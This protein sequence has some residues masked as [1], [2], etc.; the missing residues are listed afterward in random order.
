MI[1]NF[2]KIRTYKFLYCIFFAMLNYEQALAVDI[3]DQMSPEWEIQQIEKNLS[4]L[5][6]K[7]N[8]LI[9]IQS[10]DRRFVTKIQA[11]KQLK[12]A[13]DHFE[14]K[15]FRGSAELFHQFIEEAQ[16]PTKEEFMDVWKHLF[17]INLQLKNNS[18]AI[19]YLRKYINS[20]QTSDS[21]N[22]EELKRI[23]N[24][25]LKA[26]NQSRLRIKSPKNL[27]SA[28]QTLKYP[29]S[30]AHEFR[31]LIAYLAQKEGF[32]SIASQWLANTQSFSSDQSLISK[33]LFY[34]G[35]ISTRLG[36]LDLAMNQFRQALIASESEEHEIKSF[37]ELALGRILFFKNRFAEALE[38]YLRIDTESNQYSKALKELS[39]ISAAL[40]RWKD[41]HSYGIRFLAENNMR[42]NEIASF[43]DFI[44]FLNLQAG[45]L[46]QVDPVLDKN[47]EELSKLKKDVLSFGSGSGIEESD[48]ENQV[49]NLAK[50]IR[51]KISEPP[52]MTKMIQVDRSVRILTDKYF[53]LK[54]LISNFILSFGRSKIEQLNSEIYGNYQQ[55]TDMAGQLLR[56]AQH[57]SLVESLALKEQ[58]PLQSRTGIKIIQQGRKKMLDLKD[59]FA[60]GFHF[61]GYEAEIWVVSGQIKNVMN[62]I[63]TLRA[64]LASAE[65]H[66]SNSKS[67]D[68]VHDSKIREKISMIN[69][70]QQRLH[71]PLSELMTVLEDLKYQ[72]IEIQKQA[73]LSHP[74]K[75][76]LDQFSASLAEEEAIYASFT[77]RY[78]NYNQ[79]LLMTD[80]LSAWN[81]WKKLMNLVYIQIDDTEKLM[82][83]KTNQYVSM[84]KMFNKSAEQIRQ[85]LDQLALMKNQIEK[86]SMGYVRGHLVW[87]IDQKLS[88]FHKWQ[89]DSKWISYNKLNSQFQTDLSAYEA[90]KTSLDLYIDQMKQGILESW[91]D[92]LTS[93]F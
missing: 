61:H 4:M 66:I 49:V 9:R 54:A 87:Q 65:F 2:I 68:S 43:S 83:Q 89:A 20:F 30:D 86:G 63:L 23:L 45:Q 29:E 42:H 38:H 44:P 22:F 15:N 85:Q 19:S 56:L 60:R 71:A 84:L 51:S 74:E 80:L 1:I 50:L 55:L 70:F 82:I 7:L 46:D 88:K 41:A 69:R 79:K 67:A 18:Q 37:S 28:L 73:F 24:T 25:L 62:K 27:F 21:K 57:L 12:L 92:P 72:R 10:S 14:N 48:N 34:Q 40:G 53:S 77:K 17:Y 36:K 5:E 8:S 13:H 81:H 58:I 59:K 75:K 78:D 6:T 31:Y 52:L 76:L 26:Q 91:P 93:K 64:I 33:S 35:V 11:K 3:K 16:T 47:I 32:T 39:L 90:Q